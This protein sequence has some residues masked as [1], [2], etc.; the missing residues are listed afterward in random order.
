[1]LWDRGSPGQVDTHGDVPRI[2]K[3]FDDSESL[4]ILSRT[5][6]LTQLKSKKV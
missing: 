3:I 6:F 1:M 2:T 5:G 4:I